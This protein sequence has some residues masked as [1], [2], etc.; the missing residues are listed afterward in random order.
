MKYIIT[1]LLSLFLFSGVPVTATI[2]NTKHNLSV[3][4]TS[5]P[6]KAQ[7]ETEVCVFCHIPHQSQTTGKPLWNRSMPTSNYTMYDSDYMK[8]MGYP[9]VASDLGVANDTPGALSRQCMSCHDGTIAIGAVSVL[10]GV[11]GASLITMN[12]VAADGTMPTTAVGFLGTDLR[13]HHPVGI[14]YKAGVTKNFDLGSRTI[15]LKNTLAADA[16]VK[17]FT[18]GGKQYVECSSCHDPHKDNKKFLRVDTGANHAQNVVNTCTACHDKLNWVGSIHHSPPAATVYK[19]G[20]GV[21]GIYGTDKMSDL[22]CVNCHTPHNA[23]GVPYLN[24]KIMAQTCFQGASSDIANAA[25][26]GVG[27]AKDIQSVLSRL[28][29]HP[30]SEA[31]N[32][33]GGVPAHT[34]LDALFGGDRTDPN[35]GLGMQWD[36]NKHAVCMDCHNPHKA[37]AGTHIV[38]GS[39][40]G[41]PG[42]STNLVSNVLLGVP[43]VEPSWPTAWTQPKTFQTLESSTKEY[44]ICLKCH[45][46]W[47][48][49][50]AVKGVNTGGHVSDSDLTTPLTDVAWEMNINNKSGHPVVINQSARTGSYAPRELNAVQLLTPWKE[51]PGLNTM[52]CS[53]CHGADNELGGDPKGPHGSNL[54]YILKGANQYWPKK[55]DGVTLYTLDDIQNGTDTGNMCKNCHDIRHPHDKW[56]NQMA[57]KGFSCVTCHLVIPHGSPTSRLIGYSTFPAPY[58]YGGNS[59][60]M[61]G[62]KKGPYNPND[63][64]TAGNAYSPACGGGGMC[65]NSNN[66]GYD[67]NL[68]P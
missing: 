61:T 42:A 38:D 5:G 25:C 9:A 33:G 47:G 51:N 4:N 46:Y 48:M 57:N 16:Q 49:G 29:T 35:G 10:H 59:L 1:A 28:Y 54:K 60:K 18:Y 67:A 22:G 41:A 21:A 53:D 7:T 40:Y 50:N 32:P 44:Q 2:V 66:G 8:R 12:G 56:R 11:I 24:R 20:S 13:M 36:T 43:G 17:L 26:H 30:V 58:N 6:I 45:S 63:V 52:Y 23:E 65:H 37:K 27:G 31:V 3:S 15:E 39:W 34:N 55:P 19:S 62:W 64:G 68:M 14:E